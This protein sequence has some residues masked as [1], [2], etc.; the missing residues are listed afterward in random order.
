LLKRDRRAPFTAII[1]KRLV[2]PGGSMLDALATLA[3]SRRQTI[4]RRI[5]G[6]R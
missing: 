3:D 1:P 4:Q 6:C 5:A 2:R